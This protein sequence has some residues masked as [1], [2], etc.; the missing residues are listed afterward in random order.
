MS[1]AKRHIRVD[2]DFADDDEYIS[3]LITV[4]REYCEDYTRRY[5]GPCQFEYVLDG[6]PP[7]KNYISLPAFPLLSVESVKATDAGYNTFTMEQSQ[8][9]VDKD[10]QPG[11][12]Y[13]PYF[14]IWPVIVPKPGDAVRIAFT[15]GYAP[16]NVP[17]RFFQA[18]LLLIGHWYNN[19][20]EVT[21]A[22]KIGRIPV[23]VDSLLAPLKVW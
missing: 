3:I 21:D 17:K 8:Y 18:M 20:E 23:G 2:D 22:R 4:A 7:D 6:F 5:I 11:A 16:A 12:I 19:R 10:R 15:A 1:R 14:G 9:I 13:L